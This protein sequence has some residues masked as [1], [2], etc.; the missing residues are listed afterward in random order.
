MLLLPVALVVVVVDVPSV[1]SAT[2]TTEPGVP[3][4][5]AP[6]RTPAA[7]L[8]LRL[9]RLVAAEVRTLAAVCLLLFPV[10][11]RFVVVVTP[12]TV[13][14]TFTPGLPVTVAAFRTPAAVLLL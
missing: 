3:V 7:V 14:A 11:L 2:V 6:L 12:A 5:V 1:G 9:P 13:A 8:M 4:T 10:G